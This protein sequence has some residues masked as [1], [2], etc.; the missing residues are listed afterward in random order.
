[1]VVYQLFN[2]RKTRRRDMEVR[3][4]TTASSGDMG[5]PFSDDAEAE[6]G[7]AGSVTGF[8]GLSLV[9]AWHAAGG[10]QLPL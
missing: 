8:I 6:Y 1:M 10:A 2:I 7:G 5:N 3:R 4:P 9:Q